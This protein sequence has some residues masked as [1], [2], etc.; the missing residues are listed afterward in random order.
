MKNTNHSISNYANL[1]ADIQ[2]KAADHCKKNSRY[3]E[4]LFNIGIELGRLLQS[5]NIKE[6]RLQ[7][8]TDFDGSQSAFA[9]I[10]RQV[11]TI[12][13]IIGSFVINAIAE[14]VD[15]FGAFTFD[16]SESKYKCEKLDDSI[17][18]KFFVQILSTSQ[19]EHGGCFQVEVELN[20]QIADILKKYGIPAQASFEVDNSTGD[21]H[22]T[23][24]DS[25]DVTKIFYLNT[26]LNAK[27]TKLKESQLI[28]LSNSL[29]EIQLFLLLSLEKVRSLKC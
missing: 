14:Q 27:Y 1:L 19:R 3:D 12:N 23:F 15:N 21:E 18:D 24:Y 7:V 17:S 22:E 4:S 13:N 6:H 9:K 5:N 2:K 20:G 16:H 8:F 29:K 10:E 26:P 25:D 28:E 11:K